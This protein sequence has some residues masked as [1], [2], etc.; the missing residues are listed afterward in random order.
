[1]KYLI[2]TVFAVMLAWGLFLVH[3]AGR[4]RPM[5]QEIACL[6]VRVDAL[7]VM[8]EKGYRVPEVVRVPVKRPKVRKPK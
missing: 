6:K 4:I 3:E 2:L 1:M 5:K 8:A 7:Q